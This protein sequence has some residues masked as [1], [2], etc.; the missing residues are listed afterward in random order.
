MNAIGV[1][2]AVGLG[3]IIALGIVAPAAPIIAYVTHFFFY[4]GLSAFIFEMYRIAFT[5]KHPFR[6]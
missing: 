6:R 3:C 4:G 5:A 2:T 1:G